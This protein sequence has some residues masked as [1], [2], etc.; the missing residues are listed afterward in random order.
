MYIFP[1]YIKEISREGGA[2]RAIFLAMIT[3]EQD[4]L[5]AFHGPYRWKH[6][7]MWFCAFARGIQS[8]PLSSMYCIPRYGN[9]KL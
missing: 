1:P 2:R 9:F 3:L 6:V 8:I 5:F 7:M 4:L